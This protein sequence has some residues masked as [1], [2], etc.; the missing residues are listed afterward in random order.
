METRGDASVRNV[1]VGVWSLGSGYFS[2]VWGKG[3]LPGQVASSSVLKDV[4]RSKRAVEWG[5]TGSVP[6]A[7][8]CALYG[9]DSAAQLERWL[10]SSSSG[11][12][13]RVLGSSNWTLNS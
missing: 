2:H 4:S 9:E 5:W 13:R 8:A 10:E 3:G 11:E 1:L 6:E 7:I 12:M